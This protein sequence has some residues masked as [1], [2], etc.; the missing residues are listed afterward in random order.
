MELTFNPLLLVLAYVSGVSVSIILPYVV[1]YLKTGVAFDFGMIAGRLLTAAVGLLPVIASSTFISD[2]LAQLNAAGYGLSTAW[3][4]VG[5]FFAGWG[6]SQSGR[7]AQKA[8]MAR[9]R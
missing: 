6:L 7:D 1:E 5:A 3:L 4:F 2:L 8:I 9:K